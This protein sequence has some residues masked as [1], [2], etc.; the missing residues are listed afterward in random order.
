MDYDSSLD[1]ST[2]RSS[3]GL[4]VDWYTVVGPLNFSIAQPISKASSDKVETFRF[5]IGTTF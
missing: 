3:T 5:N 4:S 1:N 2:I